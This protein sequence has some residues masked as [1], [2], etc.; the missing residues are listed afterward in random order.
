[1]SDIVAIIPA[2]YA[3]TRLPG[4]ALADIAGKTLIQHVYE[5][6]NKATLIDRVAVA[7]DDERIFHAVEAFGGT[8]IMTSPDHVSGT[9][10][11]AE[12]AAA[13]GGDI[14]MNVQGDEPFIDPRVIDAVCLK[15]DEDDSIVC[16]TAASASSDPVEYANPNAVKVVIGLEGRALYFSRSPVPYWRDGG[17]GEFLV[18][19]GLYAYRREF[20]NVFTSLEPT[21]YERAEKLEQLR[22]LEHGYNI[23]V[24]VTASRSVGVDTPEDLEKARRMMGDM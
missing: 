4:K 22:M 23:G 9:D 14:V 2:R 7:T 16:A 10:R 19:Q 8:A 3:S 20:L 6:V 12:A 5:R 1:M 15:L 13:F 17:N 11:I 18:H 24:V 21:S